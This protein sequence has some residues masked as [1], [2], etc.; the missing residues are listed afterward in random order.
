MR[1]KSN[2]SRGFSLLEL[3]ISAAIGMVM[4]TAAA[5]VYSRALKVSTITEQK[6]ELQQDF[7]SASN[8]LQRDISM[9]GAGALGQQ[10]LART[11]WAWSG[12][13]VRCPSIP[14]PA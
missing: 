2:S 7:R 13:Q 5:D 3:L 9:A 1:R 6:A 14:A 10:G 12:A 11:W 8:I 4:V